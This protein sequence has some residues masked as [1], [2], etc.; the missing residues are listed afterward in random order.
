MN[1]VFEQLNKMPQNEKVRWSKQNKMDVLFVLYNVF[2]LSSNETLYAWNNQIKELIFLQNLLS[3]KKLNYVFVKTVSLIPYL[4]VDIDIL[5]DR[6]EIDRVILE[7]KRNGYHINRLIDS[8]RVIELRKHDISVELHTSLNVLG[9]L[10]MSLEHIGGPV[11]VSIDLYNKLFDTDKHWR[12]P[13]LLSSYITEL[14][15]ILDQ[16][17]VT[18]V[19]VLVLKTFNS[20][21][22]VGDAPFINSEP[23]K[24]PKPLTVD[25]I[26]FIVKVLSSY[27]GAIEVK[28]NILDL[29]RE[30]VYYLKIR[31][32]MIV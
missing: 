15:R 7:L 25:E 12:C 32:R 29:I 27:E 28:P 30:L 21:I 23:L 11:E 1:H 2:T 16:K 22:G 10:Q 18:Y 26:T 6:A 20:I 24:Y 17:I 8:G 9:L 31:T 5:T 3:A 19:V 14:L 4:H 13:D